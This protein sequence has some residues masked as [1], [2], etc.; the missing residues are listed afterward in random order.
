MKEKPVL[1]SLGNKELDKAE[2]QFEGFNEN[3]KSLTLD[4]MNVTPKLDVEPQTK[5][6]TNDIAKAQ[7][8]YLKPIKT[9]GCREK[10]NE[11]YRG[12]Y[13]F[14]KETVQFIAENKEC[15]GNLIELWTK[16]YAGIP[17]MFW[18]I[19]PNKP[20]WGPRYLA[21]RIKAC[22]YHRLRME[23]RNPQ[24]LDHISSATT[25][26]IVV[27]NC[28]NRLDAQPVSERK[29]IFMGAVNF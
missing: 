5:L 14:D 2:Q 29:S 19:P 15:P 8:I 1:N 4:R 18:Q 26:Q 12:Q 16:P 21:E 23:E 22:S 25:G 7:R 20:V 24:E 10:F 17:A 9:I 11:D 27:D 13:E 28:I 6:S 3:I